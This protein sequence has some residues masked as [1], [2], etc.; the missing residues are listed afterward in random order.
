MRRT[1]PLTDRTGKML[2]T[3]RKSRV[4]ALVFANGKGEQYL[5][6]TSINPLHR[7]A[8]APQIDG[9][10][11]PIFGSDFV[12]HSLSAIQCLLDLGNQEWTPSRSCE[13]PGTTAWWSRSASSIR[14]LRQLNRHLS[15]FSFLD[16]GQANEGDL[17]QSPYNSPY[18]WE[19]SAVSH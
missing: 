9:K 8:V 12:L 14:L 11:R 5:G 1:F 3:R 19:A 18:N 4:S 7:Q 13:S 17:Q 2:T 16:V 15:G 6:I 10:R